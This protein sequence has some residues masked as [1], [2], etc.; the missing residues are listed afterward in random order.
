M[1]CAAQSACMWLGSLH[2]ESWWH[3]CC[4]L[5]GD[6]MKGN[7]KKGEGEMKKV[8]TALAIG[9]VALATF[10][11]SAL[12]LDLGQNITIPDL[13]GSGSGWAGAQEDQE[14]E[15]GCL[16]GQQWDM[17]GFFFK[18]DYTLTMVGGYNMVSGQGGYMT[19][20]LFIDVTGDAVYGPAANGSGSGNTIINNVFG[21]DYVLDLDMATLTYDV[22]AIGNDSLVSVYY[23]QNDESNPWRYSRGGDAVQGWQDVKFDYQTGLADGDVAGLAGGT[24]NAAVFSLAFLPSGTEFISH[25]TYACGNDNLMGQF[26]VPDG[27][28]TAVLLGLAMLVVEGARRAVRR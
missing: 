27:G 25:Y 7:Y 17:E 8:M 19:G 22:Y 6:D 26:S 24:H 12:A 13:V 3:G 2:V 11:G 21:Y 10:P 9:L 14:V 20:D 4:Y 28:M 15:P 5:T 18:S 16:T 23:S 1:L